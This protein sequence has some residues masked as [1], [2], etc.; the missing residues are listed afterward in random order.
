MSPWLDGPSCLTINDVHH[1]VLYWISTGS[2]G[3]NFGAAKIYLDA[4]KKTIQSTFRKK[5]SLDWITEDQF[6]DYYLV[7]HL[8]EFVPETFESAIEKWCPWAVSL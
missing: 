6:K 7:T 2:V 5:N 8:R 4:K 3:N 1:Y